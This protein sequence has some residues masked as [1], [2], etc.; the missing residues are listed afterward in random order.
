MLIQFESFDK[1]SNQTGVPEISD[2]LFL[3][4]DYFLGRQICDRVSPLTIALE[5]RN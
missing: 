4:V 1:V 5:E 2:I 3:H